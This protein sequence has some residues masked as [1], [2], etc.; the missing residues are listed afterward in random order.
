MTL[1]RHYMSGLRGILPSSVTRVSLPPTPQ[2]AESLDSA[3]QQ[4]T[5]HSAALEARNNAPRIK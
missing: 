3:A 1:S 4:A 2:R 5:R